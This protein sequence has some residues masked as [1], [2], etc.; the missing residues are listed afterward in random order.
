MNAMSILCQDA[1]TA[2]RAIQTDAPP[3]CVRLS[4][5]QEVVASLLA[6]AFAKQIAGTTESWNLDN[7][8]FGAEHARLKDT[9][10][11]SECQMFSCCFCGQFGLND[12][13][14]IFHTFRP[15]RLRRPR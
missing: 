4:H 6:E 3:A 15:G 1:R 12:A 11:L 14:T 8:N 2:P 7:E 5:C 10:S 9:N 13:L